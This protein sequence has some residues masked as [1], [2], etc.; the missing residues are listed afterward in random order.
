M[1][2]DCT[3]QAAPPVLVGEPHD[4]RT[5]IPDFHADGAH[6]ADVGG[7]PEAVAAL[8][9]TQLEHLQHLYL[10]AY[11]RFDVAMTAADSVVVGVKAARRAEPEYKAARAH[12]DETLNAIADFRPH[13]LA[14]MAA[15]YAFLRRPECYPLHDCAES[16]MERIQDDALQLAGLPPPRPCPAD[17]LL[18]EQEA[19]YEAESEEN[20]TGVLGPAHRRYREIEEQASWARARS[21]RG[22]MYQIGL[23]LGR[24]ELMEGEIDETE[25]ALDKTHIERLLVSALSFVHGL[26][27]GN[28]PEVIQSYS[29]LRYGFVER[30]SDDPQPFDAKAFVER[31]KA[32]GGFLSVDL[33]GY[34]GHALINTCPHDHAARAQL[35]RELG[36]P[37]KYEAVFVLLK[38]RWAARVKAENPPPAKAVLACEPGARA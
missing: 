6:V 29:G 19:L 30:L 14:E 1:P 11:A 18:D 23:A 36:D 16:V 27:G 12:M 17:R 8:S 35:L 26:V 20:E 4:M 7:W 31:Y 2:A 9:V 33:D 22:A 32:A 24:L 15:K 25:R 34:G 28:L 10:D 3:A 21:L 37:V 13:G 5:V 38:A